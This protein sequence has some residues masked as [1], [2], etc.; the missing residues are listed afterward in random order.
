MKINFAPLYVCFRFKCNT[1]RSLGKERSTHLTNKMIHPSVALVAGMLLAA[2]SSG[3]QSP[4]IAAL[5]PANTMQSPADRGRNRGCQN[6]GGLTVQPC[7]V[8]F[9]AKNPGPVDVMV[10]QNGDGNGH[11]IKESDNCASR[12]IATVARDSNTRYTVTAGTATGHCIAS[13]NDNGNGPNDGGGRGQ[14]GGAT[15]RIDNAL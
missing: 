15:L 14:N 10:T 5:P 8:T 11:T 9:D 12:N 3:A 13:F 4:G 6:G 2:C 7:R 1:A